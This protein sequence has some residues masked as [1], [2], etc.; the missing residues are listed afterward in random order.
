MVEVGAETVE[1]GPGA[2]VCYWVYDVYTTS[3]GCSGSL[4]LYW[5][6]VDY[7]L[8]FILIWFLLC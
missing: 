3:V 7:I 8:E 6:F 1:E 4:M 5:L 2:E